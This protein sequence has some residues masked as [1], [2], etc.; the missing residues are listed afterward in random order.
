MGRYEPEPQK[1]SCIKDLWIFR[2]KGKQSRRFDPEG[3]RINIRIRI[4]ILIRIKIHIHIRI[5]INMN[6]DIHNGIRIDTQSVV[7]LNGVLICVLK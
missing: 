3:R 5:H 7:A 1:A 4:H 2:Y 6:V